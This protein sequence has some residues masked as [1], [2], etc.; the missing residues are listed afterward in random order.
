MER[1][2]LNCFIVGLGVGFLMGLAVSD[3]RAA[4]FGVVEGMSEGDLKIAVMETSYSINNT[5][6]IATLNVL[7]HD[8]LREPVPGAKVIVEWSTRDGKT[9]YCT[10]KEDGKCTLRYRAEP[11]RAPEPVWVK[12]IEVEHETLSY[13]QNPWDQVWVICPAGLDCD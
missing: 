11:N 9:N 3:V 6:N 8:H 12:I 5:R 13:Y 10:T 7:V 2:K 4:Q 1:N